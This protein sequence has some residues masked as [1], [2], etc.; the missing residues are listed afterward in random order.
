M[1]LEKLDIS[2]GFN[3][4]NKFIK[5][6]GG[7]IVKNF[8][9]EDLRLSILDQ[10]RSYAESFEAGIKEGAVKASFSGIKTKRFSG[11]VQRSS[12]FA[13][14]IDHDL[15]HEWALSTFNNDYWLNTAQAMIVGPGSKDQVLHRDIGNWPLVY[16]LGDKGPEATVSMMLALSDFTSENGATKVVPGSHLWDDWSRGAEKDQVAQAVM[17]AGS[18]ML[19]TGKTI[20]GAAANI[21]KDQWR[22]GIHV[23]FVLGQLTPEEAS[24][25]TVPWEI[26]QQ[27]SE[28]VKAMLGYYSIRTF[29][30]GW[31]VLWTKDYRELRDQ[32]DPI[33]EQKY[34]TAG[35][36]LSVIKP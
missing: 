2:A 35:S 18:A 29:D 28:R 12:L 7:V 9:S 31:P 16:E 14:I 25:I 22:F 5:R 1:E 24:P 27:H 3:E 11:L 30:G 32:L 26:A 4:I 10:L 33:P 17:P 6:D 21:T 15:L 36:H 34:I 20:H 8:I 13:Q 19:Y 23:S